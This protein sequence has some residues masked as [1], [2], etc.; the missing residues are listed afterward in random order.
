MQ[1]TPFY[2]WPYPEAGVDLPNGA[3]QIQGLAQAA[4]A[5]LHDGTDGLIV[6]SVTAGGDV[7]AGSGNGVN[8]AAVSSGTDTTTSGSYV[9]LGGTGSQTSFSFVKRYGGT[10]VRAQLSAS[11]Y[12]SV[13]GSGAMLGVRINGVDYDVVMTE[14]STINERVNNVGVAYLVGVPAGTWTVQGRWRRFNGAGTMTRDVFDWLS[15]EAREVA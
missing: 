14:V 11:L 3:G 2:G 10:R 1:T 6:A 4:E 7:L 13:A 5:T 8:A 12:S 15:I 9:N